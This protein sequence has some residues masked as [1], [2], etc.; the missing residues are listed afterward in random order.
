MTCRFLAALLAGALLPC[1]VA[2]QFLPLTVPRGHVGMELHT[3]FTSW[4][5][6]FRNGTSEPAG[7]DLSRIGIGGDWLPALSSAD[8]R[9]A[10]LTGLTGENL[11][12]GSYGVAQLTTLGELGLGLQVG[13][14]SR[15][16]ISGLVPLRQVRVQSVTGYDSTGANSGLNPADPGLGS[17]A[18]LSSTLAFF[19]EFDAAIAGIENRLASGTW[20]G[21]PVTEAL[22]M[23]TLTDARLMREDLY[24]LLVA[25]EIRSPFIPLSGSAVG[26][27]LLSR[28]GE[29]QG[30][31]GTG[32]GISGFSRQPALP[33]AAP[34]SEDWT[35]Y[36]TN[37]DGPVAGSLLAPTYMA[38]GD[39][40]LG[41]S[42]LLVDRFGPTV[43]G[44]QIRAAIKGTV[45]L[46][47]S[48]L[49]D[50]NRFLDLG[51]GDR[52][53]DAEVTLVT[54]LAKGRAA[55]RLA[56]WYTRQLA[57]NQQRRIGPPDR[58]IQDLATLA[59]LRKDPGDIV[60]VGVFPGYRL[61]PTLALVAGAEWWTR[62]DDNYA[63]AD[64]QPALEGL[65]PQTLAIE[66][67]ASAVT[68][69]AGLTFFHPGD[70]TVGGSGAP[71]AAS[72][73]WERVV[74]AS[75]GR[76]PKAESVRATLRIYSR[77]W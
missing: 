22:A 52:Q 61:T 48:Q 25:A 45:R 60:G 15:L 65:D 24:A 13:L 26:A 72:V 29:L 17:P 31:I 35:R 64:G 3:G 23:G 62:G 14:T 30:R 51:T 9:L 7:T 70:R 4:D 2:A 77:F 50:P 74:A 71:L 63:Y 41:A 73:T 59:A 6:R 42:Y 33:T 20:S 58:P 27:A 53:P 39:I 1:P 47:T 12:A 10:R 11:N 28:I 32:L 8:L 68:V 69:R 36:L 55:L 44:T 54:D 67:A 18:G 66:S 43:S 16:T 5:Q 76:V 57:G 37:G 19:L 56:G 40:E 49:D 75:G 46:R 34:T 38:L 21:S